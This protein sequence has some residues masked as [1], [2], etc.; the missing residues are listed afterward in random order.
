MALGV[1]QTFR[2]VPG[3]DTA[4][5][6]TVTGDTAYPNPAGYPLTPA[7]FGLNVL[8]RIIEI[9]PA[10]VAA[11]VWAPVVV[12]TLNQDGSVATAALNLVVATTGVQVANGVNVSTAVF[13]ITVEGD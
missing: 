2:T 12:T 9:R 7:L 4:V 1:V 3:A 13:N 5:Q 10:S 6:A 8:R 11:A